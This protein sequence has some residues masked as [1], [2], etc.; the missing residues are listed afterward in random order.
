MRGP[1]YSP[2]EEAVWGTAAGPLYSTGKI[3]LAVARLFSIL[4]GGSDAAFRCDTAATCYCYTITA[5]L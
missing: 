4:G 1:E 5:L 2:K 3:R